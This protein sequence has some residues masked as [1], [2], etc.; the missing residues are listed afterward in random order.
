MRNEAQHGIVDELRCQRM[1]MPRRELTDGATPSVWWL[2]L[3]NHRRESRIGADAH[4]VVL[5]GGDAGLRGGEMRALEW[6][7][8]N[9]QKRQLRVER[10]EWRGEVTTTKGN[11]V[12]Y[13]PVHIFCG[14]RSARTSR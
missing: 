1:K 12:R 4:L 11:R 8:V 6:T 2:R 3:V 5:L 9:L 13:V 10:N 14:T 7:D